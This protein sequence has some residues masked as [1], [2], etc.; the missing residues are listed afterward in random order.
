MSSWICA[1]NDYITLNKIAWK[2]LN[3]F[4]A[5]LLKLIIAIFILALFYEEEKNGYYF[6][7]VLIVYNIKCTFQI[8]ACLKLASRS[9][10]H[11]LLTYTNELEAFLTKVKLQEYRKQANHFKHGMRRWLFFLLLIMLLELGT[12][13]FFGLYPIK[14]LEYILSQFVR[15]LPDTM[16]NKSLILLQSSL[17]VGIWILP[18]ALCNVLIQS[19]SYVFS[20]FYRHLQHKEKTK[21]CLRTYIKDVREKYVTMSTICSNLD[22]ML[23]WL[24]MT[25][26]LTDIVIICLLLRV[27]VINVEDVYSRLVLV[28]WLI[29]CVM[30]LVCLSH[31][32]SRLVDK[33]CKDLI[34]LQYRMQYAL[35]PFKARLKSCRFFYH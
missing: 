20:E 4:P 17:S 25:S 31:Y 7:A 21:L 5:F 15:P 22:D 2:P 8:Y 12:V 13:V 24:F 3:V 33:V 32:S 19:L 6:A 34:I 14:S 28:S 27:M 11:K 10:S 29:P 26:Y 18:V 23:S 35:D 16:L 30:S 9:T 1:H